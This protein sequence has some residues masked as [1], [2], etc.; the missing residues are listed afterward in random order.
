MLSPGQTT[1]ARSVGKFLI[2]GRVTDSLSQ[3]VEGAA[4]EVGKVIAFSN[5]RGEWDVCVRSLNAVDILVLPAI[6]AI[7][8]EWRVVQAPADAIPGVPAA[9]VVACR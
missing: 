6:F 5:S 1:R 4:V 7:P 9:I 3:P 2:E 8:G